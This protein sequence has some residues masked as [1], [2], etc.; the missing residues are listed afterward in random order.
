MKKSYADAWLL[1]RSYW[2]IYG[3]SKALLKS[4]YLHISIVL[5]GLSWQ[6]WYLKSWWDLPISILPNL[7][8]FTLG[9]YAI[10][11][12]FGDLRFI[13]VIRGKKAGE[14]ASPYMELNS[15]FLHF[16]FLQ[17][18]ALLIALIVSTSDIRSIVHNITPRESTIWFD[19][20]LVLLSFTNFFG[21]LIFYYSILAGLAAAL[22][23][24]DVALTYDSAV[25]SGDA[26]SRQNEPSTPNHSSSNE[27]VGENAN[28]HPS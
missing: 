15:A 9:G 6:T 18:S 2:T 4:P 21:F 10:L 22:A 19:T 1:L 17:F 12:T 8:G 13:D 28:D 25:L 3:G 11:L 27:R 14:S 5:T 7:I 24:F 20:L 23:I 26:R 16:L